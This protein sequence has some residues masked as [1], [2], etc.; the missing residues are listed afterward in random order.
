MIGPTNMGSQRAL[1]KSLMGCVLSLR[2]AA[3]SGEL[4][5]SIQNFVMNIKD[6]ETGSFCIACV[7]VS[8]EAMVVQHQS[9]EYL[10]Q[11]N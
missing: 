11:R 9:R 10:K 5:M 7:A 3:I 4:S 2:G 1:L 6:T 8:K